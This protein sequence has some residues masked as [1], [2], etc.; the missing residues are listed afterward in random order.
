[1]SLI[2][3]SSKLAIVWSNMTQRKFS[4]TFG[5]Y[6]KES[7]LHDSELASDCERHKQDTIKKQKEGKG[8]WKPELASNSEEAIAAD[9]SQRDE[10]IEELQKRTAK[11]AEEKYRSGTSQGS[12][13]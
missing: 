2:A 11:H 3:R 9:R 10:S 6:L 7:N 12:G 5:R 4:A 1:M 13:L 8:H